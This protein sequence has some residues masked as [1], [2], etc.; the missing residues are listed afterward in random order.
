[1]QGI[2]QP[3]F[4]EGNVWWMEVSEEH[5]TVSKTSYH[6]H[7]E[8]SI[9]MLSIFGPNLRPWQRQQFLYHIFHVHITRTELNDLY[10]IWWIEW[11]LLNEENAYSVNLT[12]KLSYECIVIVCCHAFP[13]ARMVFFNAIKPRSHWILQN[14]F[15]LE[16]F[17]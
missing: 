12:R 5:E 14:P 11:F 1:M 4:D 16:C 17:M 6:L 13:G 10:L 7:A 9:F 3:N 2:S 15:F 8:V